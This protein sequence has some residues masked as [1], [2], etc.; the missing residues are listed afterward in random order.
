MN[1]FIDILKKKNI[2][3]VFTADDLYNLGLKKNNIQEILK[4]AI[5]E[6]NIIHVKDN[7]Y[8]LGKTLRKELVSEGVISHK[9][10]PNSY[11]S[12]EYVLSNISW[13]PEA[14]YIVTCVT[15]GKETKIETQF[16][17]YE[18]VNI[19]QKKYEAGLRR[20]DRGNNF[21]YQ[22]RPL[23]ALADIIGYME[24]NWTTLYPLHESFRIEYEDLE[25][26]TASDFDELH[27]TYG[28]TNVENFLCG[29]RK[30]LSL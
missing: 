29:I 11:A 3:S 13:I 10:V 7:I 23:K 20:I 9:L 24:Y 25:T 4:E 16:G 15:N 18:Y 19:P 22:A 5:M 26:L 2:S 8:V 14:V 17:K 21:Y 28:I 30:E 27:E 6:Y 1:G 12:M